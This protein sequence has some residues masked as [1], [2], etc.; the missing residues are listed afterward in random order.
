MPPVLR[1]ALAAQSLN[2]CHLSHRWMIPEPA[3]LGWAALGFSQRLLRP[4]ILGSSIKISGL[5]LKGGK[6]AGFPEVSKADG[7]MSYVF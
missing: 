7:F 5:V 3:L 4:L 6:S 1:G 2:P